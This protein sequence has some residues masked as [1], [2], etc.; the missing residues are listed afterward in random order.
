MFCLR[1]FE[2]D[3]GIVVFGESELSRTQVEKEEPKNRLL[4]FRME[5]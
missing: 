4:S 1:G 2:V 5:K 3:C